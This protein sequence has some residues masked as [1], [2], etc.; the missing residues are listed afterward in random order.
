MESATQFFKLNVDFSAMS[1]E[2]LISLINSDNKEALNYLLNKYKELVYMKV[3]KYFIIGAEK[4]DIFQEGMIG[5]YKAIKSYK[6]DKQNS[7]KTFANMCIERQLIT[8]IKTSNR[9]KHI[10]L[11]SYLSLNNSNDDD[12]N[13]KTLMD[14]I[15]N[16]TVEDP[17][18]TITKKEYYRTVEDT[19]DKS[20]S[21]FEK[22]VLKKFIKGDSYVKIAEEL[23][24]PVKSVDNAIQR[25]RKKALKGIINNEEM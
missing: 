8:A 2:Q 4:D 12:D 18:D 20:L 1:D 13:N 7:F 5:L 15:N 11:N 17:L 6:G 3:G 19:I 21:D 23:E 22:Q 10:P 16:N 9:Q 25:I 24:S 14:V